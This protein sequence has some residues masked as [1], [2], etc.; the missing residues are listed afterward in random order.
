MTPAHSNQQ[1]TQFAAIPTIGDWLIAHNPDSLPEPCLGAKDCGKLSG[2]RV[3]PC[4]F[5]RIE[6]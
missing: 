1:H 5:D 3:A 6:A 2:D 4:H